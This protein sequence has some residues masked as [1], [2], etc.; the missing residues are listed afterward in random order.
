LCFRALCSQMSR[1]MVGERSRTESKLETFL[2][3]PLWK[4]LYL[5]W[6]VARYSAMSM[7][8]FGV[9]IVVSL[10]RINKMELISF[11]V[12]LIGGRSGETV[13]TKG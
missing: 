12:T 6:M 2:I 8:S 9:I 13:L 7:Q 10:L 5:E 3:P 11:R 1:G 4:D